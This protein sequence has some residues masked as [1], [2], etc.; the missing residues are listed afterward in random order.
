MSVNIVHV[1]I[2]DALGGA[3][4]AAKSGILTKLLKFLFIPII[5]GLG[6]IKKLFN[7]NK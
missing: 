1:S 7:G 2:S 5:I 6:Y 4:I 3:A